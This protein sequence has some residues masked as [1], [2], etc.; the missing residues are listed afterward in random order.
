MRKFMEEAGFEGVHIGDDSPQLVVTLGRKPGVPS[1]ERPPFELRAKP[2]KKREQPPD[3]RAALLDQKQYIEHLEKTVAIKNEHI[4]KM[5]RLVRRQEKAIAR[6]S[7]T[8]SHRI[9]KILGRK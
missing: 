7:S 4:E 2:G 3:L 9:R 1:A 8:V 5:E 6:L